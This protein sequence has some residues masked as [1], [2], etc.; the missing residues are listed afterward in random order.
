MCIFHTFDMGIA[1]L[2]IVVAIV[3][4]CMVHKHAE[5]LIMV[6]NGKQF[7]AVLFIYILQPIG[8]VRAWKGS[9]GKTFPPVQQDTP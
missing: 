4:V 7:H 5:K 9:K 1:W 8:P 6:T 3:P 2:D